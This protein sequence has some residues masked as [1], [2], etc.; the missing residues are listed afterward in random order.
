MSTS[1]GGPAAADNEIAE[2]IKNALIVKNSNA[3]ALSAETGIS[4]NRLRLTLKGDRSFTFAEFRKIADAMNVK[5]SA[6]LPDEL[7]RRSAA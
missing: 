6:L 3:K 5:P 1:Q 2:R 7:T 4:Y